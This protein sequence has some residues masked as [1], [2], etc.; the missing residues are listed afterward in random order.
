[1]SVTSD[2]ESIDSSFESMNLSQTDFVKTKIKQMKQLHT[3]WFSEKDPVSKAAKFSGLQALAAEIKDDMINLAVNLTEDMSDLDV[4][5]DTLGQIE[6][7]TAEQ[8][9]K[10]DTVVASFKTDIETEVSETDATLTNVREELNRLL[11]TIGS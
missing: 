1:M 10:L 4:T 6:V 5:S 9:E 2:F 7:A 8:K 3:S 11:N